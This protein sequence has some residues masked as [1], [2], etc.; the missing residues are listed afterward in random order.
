VESPPAKR[1]SFA[2]FE[3]DVSRRVL[4]RDDLPVALNSK[5]FDLLL[6]LVEMHGEVLSKD[7]LLEKVWEGQFVEEGNLTGHIS[8]LRKVLG[9]GKKE[10]R[11]IVT[12]PGRGY[13]FAAPVV[14]H[15][16]DDVIVESHT[17][18]R[19]IVE[20]EIDEP[21]DG[22]PAGQAVPLLTEG[23][24]AEN[25]FRK[26]RWLMTASVVVLALVIVG[27]YS[28]L[29]RQSSN[30]SGHFQQISVRRLTSKGMVSDA[31]LSPDGKLFVYS[32]LEGDAQSLWLGHVDGGEPVVIRP[33]ANAVYR[34]LKFTPDGN[35]I[36][37][38]ISE[39]LDNGALFK[40]PVFG[41]VP[42]KLAD[43]FRGLAFSPDG[44]QFAYIRHDDVNSRSLLY[45]AAADT[46]REHVVAEFPDEPSTSW[47]LPTWS[48]D[49]TKIAL[50]A[51]LPN[52]INE[53]KVLDVES[54]SVSRFT[55]RSW[56]S[57]RSLAWLHDGSGFFAVAIDETSPLR[58][59]WYVSYPDGAARRIT[60]D[61]SSYDLLSL[62]ADDKSLLAVD[63][64]NQSN[65]WIAPADNL[66]GAKQVTFG[67]IGRSDGWS[68][69]VWNKNEKIA[70]TAVTAV[71]DS[72]WMMNANGSD[73]RQIVSNGGSNLYPSLSDDG[74]YLVFQSDRSGRYAIW[75]SDLETGSLVQLTGEAASFE[76]YISPDSR[77]VVYR[78]SAY[79]WRIPAEGGQPIQLT[80]RA[81]GWPQ[82]SPDS[83]L[84]A[85][86][87]DVDGKTRLGIFSLDTG[88]LI[89][90][91]ETP[92]L[93][94]LRLGVHWMPDGK[95]VAYR[96]WTNGIW[97][98]DL[99]GGEPHRLE[100]LP[101]EK[102][103]GFGWSADGK[104]FA[105]S[106]GGTSR[107]VVLIHDAK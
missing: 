107:D 73:Q 12:I 22:L 34:N 6:A 56:R 16:D 51:A 85:C 105:Y 80:E 77:W 19:V 2:D 64:I 33:A 28:F 95:A 38:V 82:I 92:R 52:D 10:H 94:N 46:A 25:A 103:F 32:L 84:V 54:G 58:Q 60:S 11:F 24:T 8:N 93:A 50:V 96:D 59:V 75:K 68:G 47:H 78:S 67:P 21:V 45:S 81:A 61:L 98:Q 49:G 7:E 102:L 76:P 4:L 37:Y 100:G 104:Q 43:N 86:E 41:G 15:I 57:I 55:T 53:L 79:L 71:G 88:A 101:E 31:A 18:R 87:A 65:I 29:R 35:S 90:A 36:Y 13:R 66:S 42:E 70:Y 26:Y 74:R 20:E 14:A 91:F 9:E 69:L 17:V 83:K 44:K 27:V 106:R 40:I 23:Q 97:I 5:A 99:I 30:D 63:D 72:I 39:S 48:P 62:S 3:I 89:K 1:F